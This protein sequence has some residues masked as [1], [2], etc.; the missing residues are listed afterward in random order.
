MHTEIA[1]KLFDLILRVCVCVCVYI[2]KRL[3]FMLDNVVQVQ[4]M[5]NV[6]RGNI[7]VIVCVGGFSRCCC[8][9]LEEIREAE[10]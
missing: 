9:C 1:D 4:V 3:R 10:M 7:V 8:C 6:C 5:M 2:M